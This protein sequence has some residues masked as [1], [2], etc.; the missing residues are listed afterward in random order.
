VLQEYGYRDRKEARR[1]FYYKA[2][3][4]HDLDY[5]TVPEIIIQSALLL[6][7]WYENSDD[8]KGVW[9]WLDLA[10]SHARAIG[11]N[12]FRSSEQYCSLRQQGL[13][14]RLWW[15]CFTR[16]VLVAFATGERPRIG[17]SDYD[18]PRAIAADFDMGEYS[19]DLHIILGKSSTVFDLSAR[20]EAALLF[21]GLADLCTCMSQVLA[22]AGIAKDATDLLECDSRLQQ[23]YKNH[24][25]LL[26]PMSNPD[27]SYVA[28]HVHRATLKA[29]YLTASAA[30]HRPQLLQ[31]RS[32]TLESRQKSSRKSREAAMAITETF[33]I[34]QEQGLVQYL[35]STGV[36]CL[37][38]A[39]VY[40]LLNA[41][42]NTSSE[43]LDHYQKFWSCMGALDQMR[44]MYDTADFSYAVL[45]KV[46]WWYFH[47]PTRPE[48]HE[49]ISDREHIDSDNSCS[50]SDS[51]ATDA[52]VSLRQLEF[53]HDQRIATGIVQD[54]PV[55]VRALASGEGGAD[56]IVFANALGIDI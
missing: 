5:E 40:Y 35:S 17:E 9:Y 27:P 25:A 11:I 22:T 55:N 47:Q 21:A 49:P 44:G 1:A 15:C 14:K 7:Y 30:L 28:F 16:H 12:R 24:A 39:A 8:S 53:H 51:E 43:R 26:A 42:E 23:W 18:V 10:M 41:S 34:L 20:L 37:L 36:T 2:K 54:G 56:L 52:Y 32:K 4:L 13:R 3:L 48:S 29:I 6:T 19:D 50:R 45:N 33:E 31:L 46:S 38:T